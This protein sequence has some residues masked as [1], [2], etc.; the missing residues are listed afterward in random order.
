MVSEI[1]KRNGSRFAAQKVNE[2]HEPKWEI[3]T[4]KQRP[5]SWKPG[6]SEVNRNTFLSF[7]GLEFTVY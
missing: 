2:H 5:E 3:T 1:P 4:Q 6:N 7:L